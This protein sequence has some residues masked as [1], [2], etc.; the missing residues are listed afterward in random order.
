MCGHAD[1]Q[2]DAATPLAAA[3]A[4]AM[5]GREVIDLATTCL[6]GL[7]PQGCM[8]ALHNVSRHLWQASSNVSKL[9]LSCFVPPDEPAA[10][11]AVYVG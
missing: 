9:D 5:L 10:A 8:F 7:L 4:A 6:G 2:T 3:A 1:A 11:H